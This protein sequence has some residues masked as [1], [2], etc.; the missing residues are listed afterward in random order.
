MKIYYAH[1]MSWY[2][3][4][5]ERD[6]IRLL[7]H[8]GDVVNPNTPWFQ[9]QV[10]QAL[11]R[12]FPVMQV[13]ADYI[14]TD[15][16]VVAFRGFRDGKV[17]AGVGREVLEAQ[18][19]GKRIWRLAGISGTASHTLWREATLSLKDVLTVAETRQRIKEGRL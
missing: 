7:E 3:T 18:V 12:D 2:N 14:R 11:E 9:E 15:A 19:W 8:F 6:D 5:D 10:E 4:T 1:P 16:D 13:F 17:G